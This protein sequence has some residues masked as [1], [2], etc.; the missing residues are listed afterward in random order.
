MLTPLKILESVLLFVSLALSLPIP[1][2]NPEHY[3]I[4]PFIFFST[5]AFL[6]SRLIRHDLLKSRL[7]KPVFGMI[8]YALMEAAAFWAFFVFTHSAA[9]MLA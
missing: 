9:T 7:S 5:A 2:S 6:L 1:N 4:Y 3:S 8:A